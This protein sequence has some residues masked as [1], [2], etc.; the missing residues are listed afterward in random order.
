MGCKFVSLENAGFWRRQCWL[1]FGEPVS[2]INIGKR[3]CSPDTSSDLSWNSSGMPWLSLE[4]AGFWR[5]QF[6]FVFVANR[7]RILIFGNGSRL[8]DTTA[9]LSSHEHCSQWEGQVFWSCKFCMC[10]YSR[11]VSN[12]NIRT[13]ITKFFFKVSAPAHDIFLC[14]SFPNINIRNSI[15]RAALS[16]FLVSWIDYLRENNWRYRLPFFLKSHL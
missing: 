1:V 15:G 6:W 12:I 14:D 3:F 16:G 9:D 5:R 11:P 13:S 8:T 10:F 7:F 4:N 2:N